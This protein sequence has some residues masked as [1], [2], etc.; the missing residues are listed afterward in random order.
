[1]G[2]EAQ[3]RVGRQPAQQHPGRDEFDGGRL[4]PRGRAR[5]ETHRVAHPQLAQCDRG[6]AGGA[7]GR[8]GSGAAVFCFPCGGGHREEPCLSYFGRDAGGGGQRGDA[9]RLHHHH[10]ALMGWGNSARRGRWGAQTHART[11][12][13]TAGRSHLLL[14]CRDAVVLFLAVILL[15]AHVLYSASVLYS[16]AVLC[17]ALVLYSALA[18]CPG[19]VEECPHNELRHAACLSRACTT[20]EQKDLVHLESGDQ[21]RA[22]A[23]DG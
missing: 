2:D 3:Q 21:P 8:A 1:M 5:L 6:Q 10:P 7:R 19:R 4:I 20:R 15:S 14:P 23:V 9:P 12:T 13:R 16:A 11:P 17:L 18:L 22:Q